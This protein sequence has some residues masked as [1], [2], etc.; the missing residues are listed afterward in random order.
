[1]V[2]C[3]VFHADG[4]FRMS[5]KACNRLESEGLFAVAALL[6]RDGAMRFNFATL[7]LLM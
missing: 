3:N 2:F 6:S 7:L 5:A 4:C 1:M